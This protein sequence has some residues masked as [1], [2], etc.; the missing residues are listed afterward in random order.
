MIRLKLKLGIKLNS[1]DKWYIKY[2][3]KKKYCART[4]KIG[5]YGVY[6]FYEESYNYIKFKE[7]KL[8]IR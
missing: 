7:M 1:F 8:C 5:K 6:I 4:V 2:K 3:L